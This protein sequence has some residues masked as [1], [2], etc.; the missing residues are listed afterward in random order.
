MCFDSYTKPNQFVDSG[1][2]VGAPGGGGSCIQIRQQYAFTVH[3]AAAGGGGARG[4]RVHTTYTEFVDLRAAV[5][6]LAAATPLPHCPMN[7]PIQWWKEF[8]GRGGGLVGGGVG[9]RDEGGGGPG[10]GPNSLY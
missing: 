10:P 9:A 4:C 7:L 8:E 1:A 5:H 6:I 2:G 3:T